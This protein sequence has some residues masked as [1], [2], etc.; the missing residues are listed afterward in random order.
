MEQFIPRRESEVLGDGPQE[1]EEAVLGAT[2][3]PRLLPKVAARLGYRRDPADKSRWR[4]PGSVLSL[5]D[6]RFF[7]HRA[8]R[9]G[10]GA[11]DLVLHA[12]GCR[13]PEAI[14]FLLQC[15]DHPVAMPDRTEQTLRIPAPAPELWPVIRRYL[16]ERRALDPDLVDRAHDTD[17]LYAAGRRN[18]VFLCR[19][20]AG[21][22]TGAERHG[23]TRDHRR[24]F[25]GMAAGSRKACG[26]FWI[27]EPKPNAIFLTESAIDALSVLALGKRHQHRLCVVSTAGTATVIPPWLGAWKPK[28]IYCGYDADPAGD[29]AADTL[30]RSN[31]R[32]IRIRPPFDGADWNDIIQSAR[33]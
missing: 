22:P 15:G 2:L 14:A 10:G 24:P 29:Q 25:R 27:G 13:F 8:G 17:V 7:D 30:A 3:L 31:P 6:G 9:G 28:R 16:V 18:A 26:S 11:I 21:T 1:L 20:Q 5:T 23:I 12:T 33:A 4:Q 32:V 19:N